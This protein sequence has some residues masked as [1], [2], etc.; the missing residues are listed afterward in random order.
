MPEHIFHTQTSNNIPYLIAVVAMSALGVFSTVAVIVLRPTADNAALYASIAGFI[1][2]TTMALLAFM[3]TQETHTLV[4]G[5]MDEFK[6]LLQ[7]QADAAEAGAR[8]DGRAQGRAE[9]V[10]HTDAGGHP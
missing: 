8:R 5:R 6:R 1:L 2:P 3:K 10:A 9:A 7:A 4:D